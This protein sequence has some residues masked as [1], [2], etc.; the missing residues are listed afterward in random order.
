MTLPPQDILAVE[1]LPDEDSPLRHTCED[2]HTWIEQPDGTV[3]PSW[4]CGGTHHA[5]PGP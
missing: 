1:P 4:G 2:G 5:F 3:Y